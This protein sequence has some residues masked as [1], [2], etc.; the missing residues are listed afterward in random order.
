MVEV[1][2]GRIFQAA[3]EDL[4]GLTP[5]EWEDAVMFAPAQALKAV[6]DLR[7]EYEKLLEECA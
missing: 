4:D 1:G 2:F 7:A 6:E 3:G 5:E